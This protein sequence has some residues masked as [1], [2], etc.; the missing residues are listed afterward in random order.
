M[1]GLCFPNVDSSLVI[2]KLG[3]G[4]DVL[5]SVTWLTNKEIYYWGDIDT[6]GFAMLDQI[7]SFLPQTKAILMTEEILLAHRK[8]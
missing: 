4:L 1:N 3:Y 7:R 2:F 8:I 5:K 6:H